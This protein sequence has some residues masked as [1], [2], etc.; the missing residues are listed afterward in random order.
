MS[1][2][3]SPALVL[4]TI[5][6]SETSSVVTLMTRDFGKVRA[7][8][9]GAR[10]PKGPF[11]SALDLLCLSNVVFIRKSNE[12]L[13]LLTEA[14][15]LRRFRIRDR[16]LSSLYGAYY[17][18]ELVNEL[19]HDYDAQ[20]ALF[21]AADETLLALATTGSIPALLLRFELVALALTGH[22]PSLDT[23]VECGAPVGGMAV[24][25]AGAGRVA[26]AQLAGGVLCPRCRPGKTQVVSITPAVLDVLVRFAD[27]DSDDWRGVELARQLAGELRGVMNH[28]LAHLIGHR[29]RMHR[30][31]GRT[32]E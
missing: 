12:A 6:F 22:A 13:D 21:D 25:G 28:Y 26:F 27:L 4:R 14:K 18:A 5:D 32:L 15:L 11:E 30:Y 2:E 24:G 1:T 19:T 20:P 16:D 17:V 7:L 3:K 8:A 31:L 9:K 29:P 23:C 10:R